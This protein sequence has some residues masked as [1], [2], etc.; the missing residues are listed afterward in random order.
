MSQCGHGLMVTSL[1][2]TVCWEG[3]I[4]GFESKSSVEQGL[5]IGPHT[6]HYQGASPCSTGKAFHL[7]DG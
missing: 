1:F 5:F 4:T 3:S 6:G 7:L 2:I